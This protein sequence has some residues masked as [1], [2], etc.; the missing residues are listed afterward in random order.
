MHG[1]PIATP[2]IIVMGW[3]LRKHGWETRLFLLALTS[4]CLG[5]EAGR[6]AIR[7]GTNN[8]VVCEPYDRHE[9]GPQAR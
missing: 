2:L 1:R 5:V 9:H 6:A 7:P 4:R 8:R 3:M